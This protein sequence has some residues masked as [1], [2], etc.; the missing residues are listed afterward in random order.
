MPKIKL[1]FFSSLLVAFALIFVYRDNFLRY[2]EPRLAS[3]EKTAIDL[4]IREIKKEVDTPPPLRAPL[5][6][7]QDAARE[8][9][10]TIAGT[11]RFTNVERKQHGLA[12]L[13]ENKELDAIARART[14]DMFAKQYFAHISPSGE[15]AESVISEAGYNYIALGENLAMGHFESDEALVAAWMA[16]PGHRANILSGKYTEIG[17]AASKGL[18]DGKEE[19]L[20]AQ[21]FGKPASFCPSIDAT[22]KATIAAKQ[23]STKALQKELTVFKSEIDNSG[24]RDEEKIKEYNALVVRYNDLLNQ[25]KSDI[26]RYNEEVNAYNICVAG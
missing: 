16:S 8:E 20:A 23:Q 14:K 15:G 10:L 4:A 21:V 18:F 25:L 19:W 6:A 2:L 26:V 17:V 9:P 13:A 5:R 22:L 3:I 7:I 12:S 24:G 1:V 11:I